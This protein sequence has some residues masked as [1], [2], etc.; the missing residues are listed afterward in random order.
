MVEREAAIDVQLFLEDQHVSDL[1]FKDSVAAFN[2]SYISKNTKISDF[3]N[4]SIVL[5]KCDFL[6]K[7]LSLWLYFKLHRLISDEDEIISVFK[8]LGWLLW[9]SSFT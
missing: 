4:L 1:C 5:G 6:N 8:L 9:K 2:E 7:L 3:L